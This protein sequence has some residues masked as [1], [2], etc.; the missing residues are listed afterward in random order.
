M[1][2]QAH[3]NFVGKIVGLVGVAGCEEI[4]FGERYFFRRGCGQ[5]I[6]GDESREFPAG[7][8]EPADV[9]EFFL[10]RRIDLCPGH[11]WP[12]LNHHYGAGLRVQ[13]SRSTD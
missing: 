7:E 5:F 2:Q 9:I 8:T 6:V 1:F 11:F 10:I 12:G 3:Q 4:L 13:V